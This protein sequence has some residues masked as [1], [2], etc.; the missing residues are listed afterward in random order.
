M[1]NKK[2]GLLL[3]G[4]AAVCVA[5]CVPT[6]VADARLPH[7][8]N[9]LEDAQ[10]AAGSIRVALHLGK[11]TEQSV[12]ATAQVAPTTP[13]VL[14]K[15]QEHQTQDAL[16]QA[17]AAAAAN[18]RI[19]SLGIDPTGVVEAIAAY[20]AD[21]LEAGDALAQKISDPIA[22]ATLEWVAL[23]N[24][25][26]KIGLQRIQAFEAAHPD[27]PAPNWLQRQKE[28]RL[29]RAARIRKRSR[30]ISPNRLITGYGKYILAKALRADGREA[31]AVN[32]ARALLRESG[33]V[34]GL[35]TKLKADFGSSLTKADYK[36]RA[37]RLVYKEQI[38][39]AMRYAAEAG[40]DVVALER[41]R[42]A[43][44]A[45]APSDKLLA[46]VPE[47]S[48]RIPASSWPKHR[49]YVVTVSYSKPPIFFRPRHAIRSP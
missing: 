8:M 23:R 45:E 17:Y 26:Q 36:Y 48:T 30:L 46:A 16:K 18:E 20:R 14:E 44:I 39:A 11:A 24:V 13:P 42:A 49:S 15:P 43:V 19:K 37:D 22:R 1:I 33:L 25:P 32:I 47:S 29:L 34:G 10:R 9:L 7:W 31:E 4:T 35:E 5:G 21:N 40:P 2:A 38:G 27:W 12:T 3:L 28:V 6:K 41:A